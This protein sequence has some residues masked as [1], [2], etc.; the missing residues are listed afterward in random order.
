MATL[1]VVQT[2]TLIADDGTIS[3][4]Q[5]VTDTA[6]LEGTTLR[7]A[8]T[9]CQAMLGSAVARNRTLD[10]LVKEITFGWFKVPEQTWFKVPEQTKEVSEEGE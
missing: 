5:E 9:A 10:E 4:H 8:L 7:Q 2:T 6:V 1:Q 3:A